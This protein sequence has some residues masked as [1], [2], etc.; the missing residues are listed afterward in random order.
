MEPH[1]GGPQSDGEECGGGVLQGVHVHL[2]IH[3]GLPGAAVPDA[4]ELPTHDGTPTLAHNPPPQQ[5]IT[6]S[7]QYKNITAVVLKFVAPSLSQ[8]T[9]CNHY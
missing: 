5:T 2:R 9:S 8:S 3:V 7:R 1:E 4:E 6:P